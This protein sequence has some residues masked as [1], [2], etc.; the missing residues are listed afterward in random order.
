MPAGYG[1]GKIKELISRISNDKVLT[2]EPHL[3]VFDAYKS[4]DK[5]EMKHEFT[6]ASGQEAFDAA[7]T[8]LKNILKELNYKEAKG[9]FV[10]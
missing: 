7:V 1:D 4:I 9:K 8:A 6:F 3:A 10:I 2:I 5:T